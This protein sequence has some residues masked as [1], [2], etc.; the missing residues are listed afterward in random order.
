MWHRTLF[1]VH[2]ATVACLLLTVSLVLVWYLINPKPLTKYSE[3]EKSSSTDF[4]ESSTSYD[5]S[6]DLH[7]L[8]CLFAG[9]RRF[10]AI[11]T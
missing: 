3:Y 5:C 7:Q 2:G 4:L 11:H 10:M 8:D 6:Y 1:C 9:G